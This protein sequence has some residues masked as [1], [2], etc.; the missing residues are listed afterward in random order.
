VISFSEA[1]ANELAESGVTV[2]CLC[3]GPTDT[4]FPHRAGNDRSRLFQQLAPMRA[5]S[6]ARKG[7]EGLMRGQNT[8]YPRIPKL[9]GRRV[10]S[11]GSEE[12]GRS[13]VALDFRA[14]EINFRAFY[15]HSI[16]SSTRKHLKTSNFVPTRANFTGKSTVKKCCLGAIEGD[17]CRK[18]RSASAAMRR[19]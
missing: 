4:G 9:A 18:G 7:Y 6:V 5:E 17:R 12:S 2:T 14:S 10:G 1:L 15:S 8:G 16:V 19:E 3:F 13:A 11:F